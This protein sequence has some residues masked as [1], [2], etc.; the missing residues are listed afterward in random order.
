MHAHARPP[1]PCWGCGADV[2]CVPKQAILLG[3][4]A[5]KRRWQEKRKADGI[6]EPAIP[7]IVCSTAVHV[8]WCAHPDHGFRQSSDEKI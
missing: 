5:M 6:T 8:C 2:A 4:L 7:N 1:Q 3:G